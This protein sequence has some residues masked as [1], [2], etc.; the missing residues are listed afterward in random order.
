MQRYFARDYLERVTLRDGT[1]VTLRLLR[2]EDRALLRAG[3][4][5]LSE[6]SRYLRF[7]SPKT[8][9]SDDELDYLCN[10]DQENHFALGAMIEPEDPAAPGI[11]VGVARF[12]RLPEGDIAEAAVTVADEMQGRGL[13]RLL[14]MRLTSAAEERGIFRFRCEVLGSN[15][16]MAGLLAQI[17]PDRTVEV[18]SGVMTIDLQLPPIPP[19]QDPSVAPPPNPAY[20]L[21]RAAAENL[22]DWTEA[23]RAF[24]RRK[25]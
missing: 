1:R 11:G 21:L 12:I 4:E 9:L 15:R 23:V 18:G 2:P 20:M 3:F 5:R 14:F 16:G 25:E 19:N 13:G 22:V 6:E 17:A 8:S 24:W 10:I 7:L